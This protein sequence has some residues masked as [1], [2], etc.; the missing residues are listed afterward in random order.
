[1]Q[2]LANNTTHPQLRVCFYLHA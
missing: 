2:F 1:M